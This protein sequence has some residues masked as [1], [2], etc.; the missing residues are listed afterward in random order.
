MLLVDR[1]PQPQLGGDAVVEPVQDRQAVAALGRGGESEQL[2]RLRGGRA[3]AAY[4]AAAAWWN[5]STMTTSKWSGSSRSQVG[6]V[7]ALDRGEDVLERVSGRAPPT[8]FSPNDGVAQR[9]A[10]GGEAL[11]EDLLAVGDEQQP[12]PVAAVSQAGVV[13]A[14]PSRSCRCRSPRRAG[15]GGGPSTAT[16]VDAVRAVAP[17][18]GCGRSSIG[19]RMTCGPRVDSSL[20]G[21]RASSNC[22]GVVVEEVAV[23]PVAVEHRIELR[24]ARRGCGPPTPARSTRCR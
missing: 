11:V 16:T 3:P 15:C 1:V 4:D 5:S 21:L 19:L 10:E 7:Q 24:R 14:P 20:L 12:R 9:V 17:G 18:T 22:V 13:D 2:D 6:G 23:R 8:H